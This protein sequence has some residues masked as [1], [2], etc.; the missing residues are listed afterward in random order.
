MARINTDVKGKN[1]SRFIDR[2][3]ERHKTKH[4]GWLEIIVCE[5]S[6]TC[7]V[8]FD[9]GNI[10]SNLEYA[11]IKNGQVRDY[12]LPVIFNVGFLGIGNFKSRCG[13]TR[14]KHY[15]KWYGMLERCYDKKCQE[16]Y[17]TYIGCSVDE[18]WHNFQVFAEWFEENYKPHMHGWHLDKDILKKGNKV[19]SPETC[20]FVPKEINKLFT[21]RQNCRGDFPIGVSKVKRSGRY[22][23]SLNKNGKQRSLG[24]FDTIEEAFEAYKIAKEEWIK[25]VAEKWKPQL[26]LQTYEALINYKVEITD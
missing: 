6:Y 15:I 3:G 10:Y 13:D 1:N 19:Y 18:K 16:K 4:Y 11:S 7:T 17:P 22:I 25:E 14:T 26:A 8:R 5:N 9:S 12:L 24:T 2:V 20:C 23:A 21:K